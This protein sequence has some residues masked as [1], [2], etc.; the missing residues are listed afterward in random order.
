MDPSRLFAGLQASGVLEVQAEVYKAGGTFIKRLTAY[1]LKSISTTIC[2]QELTR[3][4][5]TVSVQNL[6]TIQ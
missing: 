4:L 5:A 2:S 1:R 6:E 3:T